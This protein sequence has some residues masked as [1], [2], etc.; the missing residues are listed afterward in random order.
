MKE[1]LEKIGLSEFFAYICP[2]AILL[3]S[4]TLWLDPEKIAKFLGESFVK[5]QIVTAIF[6]L[7]FSYTLG[8]II[9]WW[10]I[11]GA[12]LFIRKKRRPQ[13]LQRKEKVLTGLLW[14]FHGLPEPRSNPSIVEAKL[15][16]AEALEKYS[17][18]QGLSL[19]ETPWDW[20]VLYRTFMAGRV[21]DRGKHILMEADFIHRRFLFSQGVA[22]AFFL[23][24]VQS[25]IRLLILLT[26]LNDSFPSIGLPWLVVIIL[27]GASTSF[28]L[29]QVAGRWW[30]EELF[31]TSSFTQPSTISQA[32]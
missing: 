28:G 6:L 25:F 32:D 11:S 2:G 7:I 21:G 31:L 20:L 30:E 1:I 16:M 24:A 4:L 22:L 8:L 29:R 5:Q 12:D 27:L 26:P 19:I 14:V 17:G 18:L 3:F 13:A 23:L 15:K 10:S 9:S